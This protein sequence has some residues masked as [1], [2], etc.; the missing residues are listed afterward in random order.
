MTP[1]QA[2]LAAFP[3]ADPRYLQGPRAKQFASLRMRLGHLGEVR[4]AVA[5]PGVGDLNERWR[6]EYGDFFEATIWTG[7]HGLTPH[8]SR[9]SAE[10]AAQWARRHLR[11]EVTA[12]I[13]RLCG[14]TP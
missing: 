8:D 2:L 3:G 1:G 7:S 11:D 13:R 5:R 6:P 9:G 12:E 10:Q 14:E 4:V